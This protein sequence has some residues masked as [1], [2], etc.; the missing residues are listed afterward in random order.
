VKEDVFRR[1]VFDQNYKGY[2]GVIPPGADRKWLA[3]KTFRVP[4]GF[5]KDQLDKRRDIFLGYC[6]SSKT[7]AGKLK[8]F[9]QND[10]GV[11]VLDWMTDFSPARSILEQIT[12]AASRCSAG[13]FLFTQDDPLKDGN[14]KKA[15]PRDNVVFEAGYFINAK[16]KDHVLIILEKNAKMPADLGGDIYASLEEIKDKRKPNIASVKGT[17]RDFVNAL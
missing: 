8:Q 2:V 3:T 13:I 4:F 1:V 11:R 14:R 5:W 17:I 10:L 6:G 9:L 16:G 15:V 12:E 7:T